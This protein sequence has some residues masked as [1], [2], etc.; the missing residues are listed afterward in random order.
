ME[1]LKSDNE[2]KSLRFYVVREANLLGI[3]PKN[4]TRWLQIKN[5]DRR[6]GG[7]KAKFPALE[8]RLARFMQSNP[9]AK[10]KEV[11]EEAKRILKSSGVDES[12]NFSKGWYE[13]FRVRLKQRKVT[14]SMQDLVE[15]K[16]RSGCLVAYG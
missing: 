1:Q 12:F 16:R 5:I 10:R 15:E 2:P 6:E 13:R 9:E 8:F 14:R 7:R 4:I 3:H 11:I